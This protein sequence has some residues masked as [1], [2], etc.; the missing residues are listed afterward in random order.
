[1]YAAPLSKR[2]MSALTSSGR[3]PTARGIGSAQITRKSSLDEPAADRDERLPVVMDRPPNRFSSKTLNQNDNYASSG[4]IDLIK[5]TPL[6]RSCV[7]FI[8]AYA[9]DGSMEPHSRTATGAE[10]ACYWDASVW[11]HNANSHDQARYGLLLQ[12]TGRIR[13]APDH[14]ASA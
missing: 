4:I 1:M 11:D 6:P 3:R 12:A 8:S 9:R 5:T 2:L 7:S 13:R 14:A 10:I